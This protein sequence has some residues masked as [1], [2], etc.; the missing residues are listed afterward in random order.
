M[1]LV[2]ERAEAKRI[3]P[4]R[5]AAAGV[6]DQPEV[7]SVADVVVPR[8]RQLGVGDDVFAVGV[9]EVTVP[10]HGDLSLL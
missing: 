10:G 3:L 4:E 8:L 1:K 5:R 9:V 7:L 6:R 2:P